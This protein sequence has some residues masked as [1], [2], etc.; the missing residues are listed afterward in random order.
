MLCF[1]SKAKR[2]P[3]FKLLFRFADKAKMPPCIV[4]L[5]SQRTVEGNLLIQHRSLKADRAC[6][7]LGSDQRHLAIG[8]FEP[9]YKDAWETEGSPVRSLEFQIASGCIRTVN[10]ASPSYIFHSAVTGNQLLCFWIETCYIIW[11]RMFSFPKIKKKKVQ[12]ILMYGEWDLGVD[13]VG[14]VPR[15]FGE[16]VHS[17]EWTVCPTLM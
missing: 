7:A 15:H 9:G 14:N 5:H 4:V 13:T 1:F 11:F 10:L 6:H 17:L 2:S 12:L 3:S 16:S 8:S